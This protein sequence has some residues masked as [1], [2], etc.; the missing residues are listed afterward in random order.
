MRLG[1]ERRRQVERVR[2]P[3]L[4][5]ESLHQLRH[6]AAV[7]VH[8]ELAEPG[9]S[10]RLADLDRVLVRLLVG[11]R[12]ERD[13]R[14]ERAE[15]AQRAPVEGLHGHAGRHAGLADHRLERA[16]KGER[17]HGL[18]GVRRVDLGLDVEA[19]GAGCRSS[20]RARTHRRAAGCARR[21]RAACSGKRRGV[22]AAGPDAAD[23]ELAEFLVREV[24]DRR[25]GRRQEL[26]GGVARVVGIQQPV[27]AHD[28]DAVLGHAAVELERRDADAERAGE[29]RERVLGR[30]AAR[31]A[32]ALQV[33]NPPP[34][35]AASLARTRRRVAAA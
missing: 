19:H 26:A 1:D 9:R 27:V 31:A 4:C 7:V 3:G 25:A 32:M 21:P 5:A 20:R 12:D 8:V 18:L 22:F 16:R 33:E 17:R 28:H 6:R 10:A 13:V 29:A 2:R 34:S 15:Q 35:R 14:R 11:E 23:V 24:D 30:E